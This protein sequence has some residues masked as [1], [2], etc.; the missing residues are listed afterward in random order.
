[1][2]VRNDMAYLGHD[3]THMHARFRRSA[4]ERHFVSIVISLTHERDGQHNG[5]ITTSVDADF[6]MSIVNTHHT[7]VNRIHTDKFSQGIVT[8]GKK[9]LVNALSDDTYL[10]L[11]LH[12]HGIDVASILQFGR[13]NTLIFG[14]HAF[15]IARIFLVTMGSI[16]PPPCK[17]W[18]HN[19]Q[20]LHL[21]F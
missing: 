4:D 19:I 10:A 21:R 2:V 9:R 11:L 6:S 16:G 15:H 14:Q 18:R 20:L 5:L 7:I 1:M 3:V 12:I 13:L 17:H 8:V